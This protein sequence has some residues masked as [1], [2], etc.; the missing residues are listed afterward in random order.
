MQFQMTCT[1]MTDPAA[2]DFSM[3]STSELTQWYTTR[4]EEFI[5]DWPE[6]YWWI[7]RRWK[8]SRHRRRRKA[9][10]AA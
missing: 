3:R 10:Q 2:P 4:L 8:D 5:R 9:M 1:A 7:H 6:Q